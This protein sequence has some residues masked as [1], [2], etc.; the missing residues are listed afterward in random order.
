[1]LYLQVILMENIK[2]DKNYNYINEKPLHYHDTMGEVFDMVIEARSSNKI[3]ENEAS[4]ILNLI[5]KKEIKNEINTH[6]KESQSQ[7]THTLFMQLT[8]KQIKHA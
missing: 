2:L 6:F 4:L 8:N 1:M 5:L 7:E 3:S